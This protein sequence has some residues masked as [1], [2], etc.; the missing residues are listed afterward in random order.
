MKV[1]SQ[2][3]APSITAGTI[4]DHFVSSSLI[5]GSSP[6]QRTLIELQFDG[7]VAVTPLNGSQESFNIKV[8]SRAFLGRLDIVQYSMFRN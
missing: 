5:M 6:M 1:Q 2:I 7:E 8:I 3:S 4:M